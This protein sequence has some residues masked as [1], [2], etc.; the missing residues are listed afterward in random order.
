[1]KTR[2]RDRASKESGQRERAR[3]RERERERER[4][5]E[6]L[7]EG[8]RAG[9]RQR[10]YTFL[11]LY[12]FIGICRD[13][14]PLPAFGISRD[15][16]IAVGRACQR[17]ERR[18]K[19]EGWKADGQ[20]AEKMQNSTDKAWVIELG[21]ANKLQRHTRQYFSNRSECVHF[22]PVCT[23]MH[24]NLRGASLIHA[25]VAVLE[26]M[27]RCEQ[28]R[29][30]LHKPHS[31]HQEMNKNNITGLFATACHTLWVNVILDTQDTPISE[32]SPTFCSCRF[33]NRT[34]AQWNTSEK[35]KQRKN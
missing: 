29:F 5:R 22:A 24:V 13:S 19:D 35:K 18:Q 27:V 20:R 33:M 17:R 8:G 1:M 4:K 6:T 2:G 32:D 26:W 10:Q 21:T 31:S 11:Y 14:A 12:I 30:T 34:W 25:A 23:Y 15:A 28:N 16:P 9:E 3:T 7:S